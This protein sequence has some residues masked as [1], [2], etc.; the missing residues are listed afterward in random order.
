MSVDANGHVALSNPPHHRVDADG[1]H[2][3]YVHVSVQ[4]AGGHAHDRE[5]RSDEATHPGP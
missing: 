4:V 2:H 1:A 3:E 5:S